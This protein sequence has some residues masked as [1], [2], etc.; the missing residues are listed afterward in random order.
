MEIRKSITF[1]SPLLPSVI[2]V[3]IDF[4]KGEH[5]PGKCK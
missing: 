1:S 2:Y 4:V 5:Y 3:T